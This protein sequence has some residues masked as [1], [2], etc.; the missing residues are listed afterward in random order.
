MPKERL[1]DVLVHLGLAST[2]E[3]ARAFVMAGEIYQNELRLD[4]PSMWIQK[5]E[6]IHLRARHLKYC[7]RGGL[8]LEGALQTFPISLTNRICMDVGAS[9]GGFTDC[10]L[11]NGA[12]L[13]YA[14][15]VGYGLLHYRLREDPRVVLMERTNA[16]SIQP[17]LFPVLPS[18]AS[19]DLSFI[20]VKTVLP[21]VS[22]CLTDEAEC[23]ILVKP[24]FEASKEEVGKGG[25]VLDPSIHKKVLHCV[26]SFLPSV[27]LSAFGLAVSPIKG[28]E[29]NKEFLLYAKKTQIQGLSESDMLEKIEQLTEN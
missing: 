6:G 5:T 22:S 1:I 20:S 26:L 24:Q 9:T 29:G 19:M 3:E 15:D 17:T 10:C 7:S 25:I 18:F 23:V 8:K 2:K 21:A 16:R 28:T 14:I 4:M 27:G 12:S 13:V 11:Q